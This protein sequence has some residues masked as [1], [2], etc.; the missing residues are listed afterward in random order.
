MGHA[1]IDIPFVDFRKTTNGK[2]PKDYAG[3]IFPNMNEDY[4]HNEIARRV[5]SVRE[6]TSLSQKDFA[7][8]HNFNRAQYNHWETGLRRIPVESAEKLCDAYGVTLDFIYRGRRDAL[9]EM[10]QKVL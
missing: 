8:R 6:S 1:A 7:E 10:A 4:T 2:L 9:S 3:S 5:R